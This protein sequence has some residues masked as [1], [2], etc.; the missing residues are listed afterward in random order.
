MKLSPQTEKLA[1]GLTVV[2]APMETESVTVLLMVRVGSRD[3]SKNLNGI[4]H[5]FEHLV[6]KGT[7]KWPSAMAV[8]RVIDSVG[9]VFNAFTSQEHTGFWVK[10]AKKHLLLGLDFVNQLVFHSLLPAEELAKERGVILEEIKMNEDNPMRFVY[11]KF[12]SQVYSMTSLGRPIIGRPEN[13]KAVQRA[14]FVRHLAAWYQPQNMVLALAGGIEEKVAQLAAE[15]FSGDGNPV[16]AERAASKAAAANTQLLK[17]DIQQ[18]HFC[19]GLPTF[20]RTHPDRYVLAL[21]ALI[22]GGNTSSRLWEEIRE[23]RGLVYYIRASTD[24]YWDTGYLVIQAGCD[25]KRGEEAIKVSLGQLRQMSGKITVREL[26]EA[27]EYLKGHL[28]LDLEDS[29]EVADLFGED[30]LL[31]GKIRTLKEIIAGVEAVSADQ[32]RALARKLLGKNPLHLTIVSPLLDKQKFA[33]LIS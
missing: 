17:K 33:K 11:D 30:L 16:R 4:S 22:L 12:V 1:N 31:E 26:N 19:L 14:D 18:L 10:L 7:E 29:Q 25:L 3:E 23:K 2:S 5:F 20:S 28:A 13:I 27:Q 24:A 21:L 8:N 9:G 32:I 6:F 15:I